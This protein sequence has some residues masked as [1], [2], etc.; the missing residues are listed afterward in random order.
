M[1]G[2][3]AFKSLNLIQNKEPLLTQDFSSLKA[4][5]KSVFKKLQPSRVYY[6]K[7]YSLLDHQKYGKRNILDE[8]LVLL[9]AEPKSFTGESN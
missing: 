9:F 6:R 4:L 3:D 7:F 2:K 1:S 5:P 8:G